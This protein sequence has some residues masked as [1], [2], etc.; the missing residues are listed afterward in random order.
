MIS[1]SLPR[2]DP[3]CMR[4]S[5]LV[6]WDVAQQQQQQQQ[7]CSNDRLYL[8]YSGKVALDGL[9]FRV[10]VYYACEVDADAMLLTDHR[11]GDKMVNIGDVR[12]L[13]HE[14]V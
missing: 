5:S 12:K 14:T 2:G 4:G 8:W 9:G 13:T 6:I 10:E 1:D 7:Q 11:H 3:V